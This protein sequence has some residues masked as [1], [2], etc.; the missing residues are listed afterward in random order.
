M[1]M[2]EEDAKLLYVDTD[3]MI[4]YHKR[5][6]WPQLKEALGVEEFLGSLKVEKEDYEILE[7]A[8][9]GMHKAPFV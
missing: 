2:P 3:S 1:S 4:V 6:L 5:E 8:S 9:G 7:Y